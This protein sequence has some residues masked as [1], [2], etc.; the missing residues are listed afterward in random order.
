[1]TI[2]IGFHQ[3]CYRNFEAYYCKQVQTYWRSAFPGLTSYNRFALVDTGNAD[4][5]VCLPPLL[6]WYL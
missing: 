5:L 4:S 1:M 6:L 2:L 3:S